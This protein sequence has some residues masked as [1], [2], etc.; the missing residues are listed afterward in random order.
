[1]LGA[2]GSGSSRNFGVLPAEPSAASMASKMGCAAGGPTHATARASQPASARRPAPQRAHAPPPAPRRAALGA[3]EEQ[4]AEEDN[5]FIVP[6]DEEIFRLQE[7]QL[8]QRTIRKAQLASM[9]VQV[10]GS[11][12]QGSTACSAQLWALGALLPGRQ[13]RSA[14]GSRPWWMRSPPPPHPRLAKNSHPTLHPALQDKSTFASQMQSTL[15]GDLAKSLAKELH[16]SMRL[17]AGPEREREAAV[18]PHLPPGAHEEQ[19]QKS[20]AE[21]AMGSC[22]PRWG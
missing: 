6:P 5:P 22:A 7:Q 16:S 14:A 10:G 4:Q 20:A 11:S 21:Q 1:M 2:V 3:Q 9:S 12:D 13:R 18:N 17:G 15:N 19:R 8:H